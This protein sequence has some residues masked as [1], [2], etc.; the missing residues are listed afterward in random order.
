MF[1]P[2]EVSGLFLLLI[3]VAVGILGAR[4]LRDRRMPFGDSRDKAETV[5][6][7]RYASGLI[8]RAEYVQ[9]LDDLRRRGSS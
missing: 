4:F 8:E 1:G 7:E 5:L 9:T 3:A 2:P 6:R